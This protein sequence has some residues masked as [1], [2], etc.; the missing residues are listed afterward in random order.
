MV[1]GA[2]EDDAGENTGL[3]LRWYSEA[4]NSTE[5]GLYYQKYTSRIPYATIESTGAK[6]AVTTTD[7][8]ASTVTR[9]FVNS[10]DAS[11]TLGANKGTWCTRA[12]AAAALGADYSFT[13]GNGANDK[14]KDPYGVFS[15]FQSFAAANDSGNAAT[16]NADTFSAF[17][18]INCALGNGSQ[19]DNLRYRA[20]S[21]PAGQTA[22]M[23]ALSRTGE[24]FMA[25]VPEY[26]ISFQY[27]QDIEA[28]G[29]SFNTTAFG[30]GIQSEVVY[31][32]NMPLQVDTDSLTIATNSA[33]CVWESLGTIGIGSYEPKKTRRVDCNSD[34]PGVLEQD[35]FLREGVYNFD[36]GTTATFTRSNPVIAALGADIGVLLTEFAWEYVEDMDLYRLPDADALLDGQEHPYARL[37]GRCTSGSDLG[38]GGLL[39]LDNRPDN[40]CRPTSASS[41]GLLLARLTYN[42][43]LGT[44][45]SMSPTLIY[46]EGL[47]GIGASPTNAVE[48]NSVLGVRWL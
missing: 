7:S 18:D 17:M 11:A 33:A 14:I 39:A 24:M 38:L 16:Y 15:T 30:W 32:R 47:F 6:I 27:P 23:D 35:G 25:I 9:L 3:A 40:Y 20:G 42:N 36:I 34:A 44:P 28:I 2:D 45:I 1:R 4:L 31:R 46:R 29:A 48:G 41:Q 19:N 21:A 10:G 8:L 5:F 12:A 22:T 26:N 43:V 37:Q 13:I